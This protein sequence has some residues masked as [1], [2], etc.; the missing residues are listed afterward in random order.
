MAGGWVQGQP[1]HHLH[2]PRMAQMAA[3]SRMPVSI[4]LGFLGRSF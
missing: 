2:I 1:L 4:S 3:G